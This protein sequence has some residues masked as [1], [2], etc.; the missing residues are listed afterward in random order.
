MADPSPATEPNP[1]HAIAIAPTPA[2]APLS[3]VIVGNGTKAEAPADAQRLAV[4]MTVHPR[5]HLVGIDLSPATDLSALSADIALVL[6][7]DGTV[8][9]A[10]RR[11]GDHP[12]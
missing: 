12:T 2:Q 9:H 3:V 1:S 6:G 4:P 11:M 5:I 7:G 10:A 8:L